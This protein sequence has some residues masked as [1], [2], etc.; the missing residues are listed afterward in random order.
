MYYFI[1]YICNTRGN[2]KSTTIKKAA[3]TGDGLLK[4]KSRMKTKQPPA[5]AGG[6]KIA[7]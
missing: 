3:P 4:E 2:I 7:D 6:F 5:E 1:L